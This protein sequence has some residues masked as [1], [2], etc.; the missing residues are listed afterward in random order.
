M[1]D[2]TK[3][4]PICIQSNHAPVPG[5]TDEDCLYL[6]IYLPKQ[7]KSLNLTETGYPVM[8]WIH[9]GGYRTGQPQNASTFVEF[10]QGNVVWVAINYRLNVF[11]FLGAKELRARDVEEGSTGNYGLQPTHAST[12]SLELFCFNASLQHAKT[13]TNKKRPQFHR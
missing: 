5:K 2:A 4:K 6:N 3:L 10:S 8:V 1:Y 13:K 9:G 12:T 7:H 11:G